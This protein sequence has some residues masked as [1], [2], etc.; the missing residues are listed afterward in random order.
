GL[1]YYDVQ[2][3][4]FRTCLLSQSI[5]KINKIAFDVA[6]HLWVLK[7]SGELEV[8]SGQKNQFK[9]LRTY[10]EHSAITNFFPL[11]REIFFSTVAGQLFSIDHT[12]AHPKKIGDFAHPV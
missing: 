1:S 10:R 3:D 6:G 5:S 12:L 9:L 4:S 2:M 7:R 11:N 8:L